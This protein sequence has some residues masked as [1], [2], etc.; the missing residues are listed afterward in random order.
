MIQLRA[1]RLRQRLLTIPRSSAAR[2]S[3]RWLPARRTAS[4]PSDADGD[5]LTFSITGK[6]A[7]AGFNAATGRLG[8]TPGDTDTGNYG[9]IVISV[10]DGTASAALQAFTL[11]V[12]PAP[13]A[14]GS[15]TLSWTAPVARTDGTPLSL[16]ELAG[17]RIHYGS[18]AGNYP[19]TVDV[20]DG[21]AQTATVNNLPA[22][23]YYAVMTSYDSNGL[24]SAYS[25][26]VTKTAR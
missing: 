8:G 14:V 9:N 5:T 23:I 13:Q 24:E 2:P 16:S 10:S 20:S 12:D 3:A 7:W 4:S 15:F 17:Y 21:S 11:R 22:G 6:P 19:N 25:A 26:E 18:T 1:T